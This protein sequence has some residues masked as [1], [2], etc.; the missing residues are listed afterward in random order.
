MPR[1]IVRRSGNSLG[2]A[3][4]YQLVREMELAPG[5]ELLVHLEK[6]PSYLG[7]EGRLKGRMTADEFT[8][9]SNEGEELA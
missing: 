1:L 6:V 7:L 3:L 4:P 8:R 5:D 2:L 9:L